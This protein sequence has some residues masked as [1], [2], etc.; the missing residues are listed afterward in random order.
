M[1]LMFFQSPYIFGSLPQCQLLSFDIFT[2]KSKN[3]RC[4]QFPTHLQQ[5]LSK[6]KFG[7]TLPAQGQGLRKKTKLFKLQCAGNWWV[8]SVI[9]LPTQTST[10]TR[11]CVHTHTHTHA[12][13]FPVDGHQRED[14]WAV[15]RDDALSLYLPLLKSLD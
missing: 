8:L 3:T 11:L 12:R 9:S 5:C 4:C 7:K 13:V 10:H 1:L 14:L 15:L 2:I 6:T